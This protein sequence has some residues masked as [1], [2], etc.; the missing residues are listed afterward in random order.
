MTKLDFNKL[1][2]SQEIFL[3]RYALRFTADQD[4]ASDLVQDTLLKAVCSWDSLP[5]DV[6]VKGWLF[7]ILKNTYINNYKRQVR[8]NKVFTQSDDISYER[9]LFSATG[10]QGESK[11]ILD[12]LKTA[13][14]NLPAEYESPFTMYFKGY[15]YHEIADQL[16]I[17]I[18]TVKTRIYVAR[19]LLKKSLTSYNVNLTKRLGERLSETN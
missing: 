11:F 9:L 18:G 8:K 4:D 7:T 3:K 17:P 13:L 6:N 16:I 2:V 19:K 10:N 1:V 12:D 5:E 14:F 15:K